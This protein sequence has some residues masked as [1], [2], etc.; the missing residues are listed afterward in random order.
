MTF[1]PLSRYLEINNL[2][3]YGD[4]FLGALRTHASAK[5]TPSIL[6]D[7]LSVWSIDEIPKTSFLLTLTE[8]FRQ[9]SSSDWKQLSYCCKR[10]SKYMGSET[11]LV[12]G[13][14]AGE[15]VALIDDKRESGFLL[16]KDLIE[17]N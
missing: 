6:A 17:R 2:Q 4:P 11:E 14:T 13:L 9:R 15:V 3:K 16:I 12:K 7:V 1:V 8:L 10:V 5:L